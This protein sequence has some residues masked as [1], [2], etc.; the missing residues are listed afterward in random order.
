MPGQIGVSAASLASSSTE[1]A[2]SCRV[3]PVRNIELESGI[4]E[5]A[6]AGTVAAP[7]QT[8]SG[9]VATRILPANRATDRTV[10]FRPALP[11]TKRLRT[12]Q[13]GQL[14]AGSTP[15]QVTQ[16]VQSGQLPAGHYAGHGDPV[17]SKWTTSAGITPDQ[18][19]QFVQNLQNPQSQQLRAPI[20]PGFGPS[21]SDSA[22]RVR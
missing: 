17:P 20:Q 1:L 14:P 11:R 4:S 2:A 7:S 13:S 19:A 8:Q 5:I 10:S 6:A 3:R 22:C 18:V 21:P 15:D 9:N 12:I 16:S